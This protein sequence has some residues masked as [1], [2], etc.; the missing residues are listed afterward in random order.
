MLRLFDVR[1][2]RPKHAYSSRRCFLRA[3]ALGLFGWLTLPQLLRFL[4]GT[5]AAIHGAEWDLPHQVTGVTLKRVGEDLEVFWNPVHTAT[6]YYRLYAGN[7]LLAET[8]QPSVFTNAQEVGGASI[9]VVA[10]DPYG[11]TSSPS[12]P[13]W[14]CGR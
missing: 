7:K 12:E 3:G 8:R 11:N 2:P 6:V 5:V 13:I 10:C 14:I 4:A 9:T 1:Q